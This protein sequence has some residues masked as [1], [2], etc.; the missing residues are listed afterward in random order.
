MSKRLSKTL[1]AEIADAT[2]R[3]VN[4]QNR[5]I[6]LGGSLRKHGFVPTSVHQPEPI[7]DRA[8]L[9]AWLLATYSPRD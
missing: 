8:A 7:E 4:P 3:V 2:L 5:A 6:A 1:A 9:I